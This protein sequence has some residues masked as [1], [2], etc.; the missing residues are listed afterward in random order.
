MSTVNIRKHICDVPGC[1]REVSDGGSF[2]DDNHLCI[3]HRS[4]VSEK[5]MKEL[6][7]ATSDCIRESHEGGTTHLPKAMVSYANAWDTALMEI[8]HP[9]EK[10][11]TD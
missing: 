11:Q 9:L 8:Q 1:D 7:E 2:W 6:Q 10:V 4:S 3:L 5:T